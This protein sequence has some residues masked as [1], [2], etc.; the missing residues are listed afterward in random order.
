[1]KAILISVLV[2]LL[3]PSLYSAV[4]VNEV[5]AN[6]PGGSTSLEWVELY[7]TS[8]SDA[9]LSLYYL[10]I[11][12]SQVPLSGIIPGNGYLVVCRRLYAGGGTPG[13]ESQW[14]NN[15]GIWGDHP[16][17]QYPV[18]EGSFT[19]VNASGRVEVLRAGTLQS[20]LS[21]I[22][23]GLDGYSWERTDPLG[24]TIAQCIDN[25][26]STPGLLN[27]VTPLP[28]DLAIADLSAVPDS[29]RT[30]LFVEIENRGTLPQLGRVLL[31]TDQNAPSLPLLVDT[32]AQIEPGFRLLRSYALD[33]S[34]LYM[35]VTAA[36]E[37]DDRPLNDTIG[38][39]IPGSQY[40]AVYLN[41][42]LAN[43][44]AGLG[45][46]WVEI[47]SR[48]SST[49]IISGWML[50]DSLATVPILPDNQPIDP[51]EHLIIAQDSIAFKAYYPA[52]TGRI[53]QPASWT[54][55]NND[56]DLVRLID[57]YGY[58]A[59]RRRYAETYDDNVTIARYEPEAPFG[60]WGREAALGGSPGEV[61]DVLF[62]QDFERMSI[63]ITPQ[64]FSPDNDGRDD[65]TVIRV[66]A[67][68]A[69]RY[70]IKLYDRQGRVVRTI[71]DGVS[72]LRDRYTWDGRSDDGDRLP[73]GMYILFVEAHGVESRKETIVIAR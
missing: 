64:V 28:N 5:L 19:L 61:N 35:A 56:G 14:G 69:D 20:G 10:Q 18:Q 47:V 49:M 54:D 50:G 34:G 29:G 15:S 12:A 32:L 39:I 51:G 42:I 24:V 3:A 26:G 67:T 33:P 31:I 70:T 2:F 23:P 59:D 52:F 48:A 7:N 22:Q 16:S 25:S 37:T 45:S 55:F 57:G 8:A 17:E 65:T 71:V 68:P 6:E 4:I 44:I 21:W 9:G 1:M 58:L 38:S 43:P 36:V 40:P 41:E 66:A 73:I 62:D 11:G 60:R 13:F 53:L 27:S 72:L 63:D 30:T 46:E